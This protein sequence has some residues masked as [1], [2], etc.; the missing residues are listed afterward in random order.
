MRLVGANSKSAE[1]MFES[2][3]K[4]FMKGTDCPLYHL[5]N[6]YK[7]AAAKIAPTV[8]TIP[9]STT[10]N[11]AAGPALSS[12]TKVFTL[13]LLASKPLFWSVYTRERER[14]KERKRR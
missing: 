2:G 1:F 11:M 13:C 5:F 14:E 9:S 3:L 6:K 12:R 8:Y 4:T 10:K 7:A